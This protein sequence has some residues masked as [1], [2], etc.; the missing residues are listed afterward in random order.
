M[1]GE[2]EKVHDKLNEPTYYNHNNDNPDNPDI[3]D[4]PY[5]PRVGVSEGS[6]RGRYESGA[7]VTQADEGHEKI[8]ELILRLKPLSMIGLL[9]TLVLIFIFQGKMYIYI[10]IIFIRYYR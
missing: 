1:G 4:N 2:A 3:A 9:L 8:N 7:N 5:R 10:Y 6:E